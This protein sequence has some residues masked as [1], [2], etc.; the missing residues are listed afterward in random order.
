MVL[1]PGA[2]YAYAVG[3][4]H[5]TRAIPSTG[6]VV[7][8]F[9][10][11][12]DGTLRRVS[13]RAVPP[14]GSLQVH[15]QTLFARRGDIDEYHIAAGGHLEPGQTI[16]APGSPLAFAPSGRYAYQVGPDGGLYCYR[17]QPDGSL[18]LL[19]KD[20]RICGQ[21][22]YID[23]SGRFLYTRIYSNWGGSGIWQYKIDN[24]GRVTPLNP[25]SISL[26]CTNLV[27]VR[28]PAPPAKPALIA[29]GKASAGRKRG[30]RK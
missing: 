13:A 7:T 30:E 1:G 20:P 16:P 5:S 4:L 6:T 19:S 15:G 8:V 25:P 9:A 10:V 23:P 28:L 12:A 21:Q 18:T 24:D 11:R 2:R 29:R 3:N 17:C 14:T 27:I 22:A 26:P